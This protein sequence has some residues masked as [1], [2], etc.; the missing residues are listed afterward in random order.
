MRDPIIVGL[1][2]VPPI[3]EAAIFLIQCHIPQMPLKVISV[4]A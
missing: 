2:Q 1:Y 4:T 3:L